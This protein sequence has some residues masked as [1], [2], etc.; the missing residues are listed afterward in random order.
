MGM[1]EELNTP[2]VDEAIDA[3]VDWQ[4]ERVHV[5]DA[6]ARWE[7]AESGD[8][9]FAFSAYR[10]ALDREEHASRVYAALVTEIAVAGGEHEPVASI[11]RLLSR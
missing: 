10:A 3:Y 1:N 6:Y 4:E 5:W 9:S 2:R 11:R 7:S 8:A